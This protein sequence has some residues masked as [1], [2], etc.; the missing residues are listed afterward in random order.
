EEAGQGV[1][2]DFRP[3]AG[4][5]R[6]QVESLIPVEQVAEKLVRLVANTEVQR[7]TRL[8]P[9]RVAKI[10]TRLSAA[11]LLD[12]S[13][14]LR[15]EGERAQQEVGP[16]VSGLVSESCGMAVEL[17]LPGAVKLCVVVEALANH[18]HAPHQIVGSLGHAPV[19]R[20]LDAAAPESN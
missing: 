11:A 15:E 9:P 1:L 2:V 10:P 17:E 13:A 4:A 8:H 6:G 5:I 18:V 3:Y 16:I 7:Q 20:D 12:L 19:V 14:V